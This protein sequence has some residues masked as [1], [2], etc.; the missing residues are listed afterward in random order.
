M[1][2]ATQTTYGNGYYNGSVINHTLPSDLFNA[3]PMVVASVSNTGDAQLY[4]PS[5]SV[6]RAGE[7]NY[8]IMSTKSNASATVNV[9]FRLT[10]RWK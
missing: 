4:Y 7:I 9:S 2:V 1:T 10:G 5:V 8:S 3:R 6:T